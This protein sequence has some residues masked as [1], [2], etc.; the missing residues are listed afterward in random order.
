MKSIFFTAL[1]VVFFATAAFAQESPAQPE[2]VPGWNSYALYFCYVATGRPDVLNCRG[3]NL[4]TR[5]AN[6]ISLPWK[7]CQLMA[8]EV[9][10]NNDKYT[11]KP[12]T[13]A[14]KVW[15]LPVYLHLFYDED[16]AVT[17]CGLVRPF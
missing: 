15:T 5:Q 3:A 7:N 14:E 9:L 4:T 12:G 1:L 16:G 13:L 17:H 10:N 8:T 6:F 11:I 2:T